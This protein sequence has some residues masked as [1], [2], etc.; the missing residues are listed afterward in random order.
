MFNWNAI[1][2]ITVVNIQYKQNILGNNFTMYNFEQV[3]QNT[4][5][6]NTCI[7]RIIPDTMH[8][9]GEKMQE[10]QCN[11]FDAQ[12]YRLQMT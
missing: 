9:I 1:L 3:S 4:Y 6:L 12:M 7:K 10:S 11:H 2:K 5:I 8:F